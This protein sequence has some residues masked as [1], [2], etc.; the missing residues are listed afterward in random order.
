MKDVLCLCLSEV[1]D[2]DPEEI[3]DESQDWMDAVDRDGLKLVTNMAYRTL[4]SAEVEL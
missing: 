3:H 4:V 1:N 2:I